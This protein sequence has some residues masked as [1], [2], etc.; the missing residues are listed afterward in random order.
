MTISRQL[1]WQKARRAA[2]LC[3][4]CGKPAVTK[5]HCER[6]REMINGWQKAQGE[7]KKEL[8][9]CKEQRSQAMERIIDDIYGAEKEKVIADLMAVLNKGDV[10]AK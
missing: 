5:N 9:A 6:H 8:N 2:G 4:L 1:K 7:K 10:N 3:V